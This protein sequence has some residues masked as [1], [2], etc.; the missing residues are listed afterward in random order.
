MIFNAF[1]DYA[2]RLFSLKQIIYNMMSFMSEDQ[3][4]VE[5]LKMFLE[6]KSLDEIK[7]KQDKSIWL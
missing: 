6:V 1:Y 3:S 2:N 5:E 7:K 4:S